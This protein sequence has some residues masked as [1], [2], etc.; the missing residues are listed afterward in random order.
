MSMVTY[1][2][3]FQVLLVLIALA[4]LILKVNDKRK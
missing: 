4:D 2:G 3:L 1:E